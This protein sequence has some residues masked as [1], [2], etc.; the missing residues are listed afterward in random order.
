[1]SSHLQVI[2][3]HTS[4][5]YAANGAGVVL[6]EKGQFDVSKDL[7]TQ[8][9][10]MIPPVFTFQFFWSWFKCLIIVG[11]RSCKWKCLCP[12]ARCVD[13]FGACLFCSRKFCFGYE[14]GGLFCF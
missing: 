10:L 11:S 6:A 2:V 14:N 3:Q 8:V 5:L 9:R 7:F 13:K 12:D 4:N 1:M